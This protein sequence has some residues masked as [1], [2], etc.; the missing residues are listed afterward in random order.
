ME[1]FKV[2]LHPAGFENFITLHFQ[3]LP[4]VNEI[5]EQLNLLK[6]NDTSGIVDA[7]IRGV[8]DFGLPDMNV[9]IPS[10]GPIVEEIRPWIYLAGKLWDRG[11]IKMSRI[12]VV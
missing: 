12:S 8:Q 3:N 10:G 9:N 7:A 11:F 6:A 4:G 5:G 1:I 2:E